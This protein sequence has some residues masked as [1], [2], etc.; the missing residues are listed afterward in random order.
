MIRIKFLET[1]VVDDERCGTAEEERFEE[2]KSYRLPDDSARHWIK[3]GVA[4]E[5]PARKR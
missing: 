4:V 2:G 1:R 5:V 3:R